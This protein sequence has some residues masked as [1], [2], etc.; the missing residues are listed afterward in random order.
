[1]NLSLPVKGSI[2]FIAEFNIITIPIRY[3]S[4]FES[5]IITYWNG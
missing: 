2:T 5:I 3:S 4:E 1:M